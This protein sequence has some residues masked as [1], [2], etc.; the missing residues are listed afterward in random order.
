MPRSYFDGGLIIGDSASLLNSQRLKGIHTA[1]KSGMLAAETIYEALCA[2]D[3]SAA[4][5]SAY[6]DKTGTELAEET[7]C[8]LVRNFHQDFTMAYGKGWSTPA[9]NSSAADAA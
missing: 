8:G 6:R 3:T 9:C 7:N 5:L 2:G 4:K 1:I